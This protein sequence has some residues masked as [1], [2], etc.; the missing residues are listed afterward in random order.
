MKI[1]YS[2][3]EHGLNYSA[4]AGLRI[5]GGAV[6]AVCSSPGGKPHRLV[7]SP[8][9]CAINEQPV[10]DAHGQGTQ[11]TLHQQ[12]GRGLALDFHIRQY[13]SHPFLLLRLVVHN[14]HPEAVHLHELVL[15]QVA[16]GKLQVGPPG[17]GLDFFKVGWHG[18]AYT[19]LRHAGEG[20]PFSLLGR[21]VRKQY[22]NPTTPIPHRRGE[23]SSEGWAILAGEQ[24]G[25]VVGL[26]SLADQFGQVAACCRPGE[27]SLRLAAQVDGVLLPPGES[28]ASEWGYL[29]AVPLPDPEPAGEYVCAVARQMGAR[30]QHIPALQWSHWYHIYQD[31]SAEKFNAN[32][33][34][35]DG[36]K[37]QAPFKVVQLDDGYQ[38][39]WG[40]WT[41]P[42]EKFPGGLAALAQG[43]RQAGYTPGLWLAPFVVQP[44]SAIEWEHP[45]WLLRDRRG[46]PVNAGFYYQFFGHALDPTHPAVQ[47]HLQVLADTLVHRW[48]F[49]MLKLDFCCAGAL[50]G[51]RYDPRTT[52][53]QA[54]RRG[55]ARFRQ[56]AGD[57]TFLLGCGCPFGPAIGLLDAMR[58]GS[59]TAPVW[60]PWFNWA[61]W[62][63]R[64]LRH[65]PSPPALRNSLRHVLNL[66]ALHRRW[67]WNDPDC[68]LLRD[69]DTRLSADEVRS[70]VTLVGLSGGMVVDSDDVACLPSERLRLLSLLTP[71][72]SPGGGALDLLQRDMPERYHVPVQGASGRWQL[73]GL[74]NW[75]DCPASQRLSLASLGFTPGQVVCV[76]DF[77]TGRLWQTA[78]SE[79]LIPE[80]P[81]HGCRLL[82]L[83]TF[84]EGEPALLGSTLHIT[85]GLELATWQA[86][87]D[88]LVF[89][90]LDLGR[91][92]QGSLWLRL[93][94]PPMRVLC[95]GELIAPV[96]FGDGIHRLDVNFTGQGRIEVD[97]QPA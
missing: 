21:L 40:D 63:T 45:D 27:L 47:E 14:L 58:I 96:A 29:Q 1:A 86:A 97:F 28:F 72:L 49:G 69:Q 73:V 16:S 20:E 57:D 54:L 2:L 36:V 17:C 70:S 71:I 11:L 52:R 5:A 89:S 35:L 39:A 30:T 85:Q 31:I 38:A 41:A 12:D 8:G 33:R 6:Y 22:T 37:A 9:D 23:F 18:W 50:P 88:R 64:L 82:R 65:E 68:L 87:G 66:S 90:T 44:G 94:Y 34:A 83:C 26:A 51:Q 78:D 76:F 43:V 53:A 48:G 61:P 3:Q 84:E 15:L 42:N 77:W 79:L 32:L 92:V 59:D 46:R 19:G 60:E 24:V 4:D 91:T 67:W 13:P 62:A 93:P 81:A 56:A 80:I 25:L 7:L 75:Q 55:L 95:N 10:D 74:V